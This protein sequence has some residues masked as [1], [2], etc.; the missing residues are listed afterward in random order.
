MSE[1]TG[2]ITANGVESGE[3]SRV[4]PRAGCFGFLGEVG[5]L[6]WGDY[7]CT[8]LVLGRECSEWMTG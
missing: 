4:F 2:V 3:V 5:V 8:R 7:G 6:R 1:V